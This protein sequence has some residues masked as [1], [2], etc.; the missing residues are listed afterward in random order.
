MKK[1][2][3]SHISCCCCTIYLI[4]IFQFQFHFMLSYW[5]MDA[6]DEIEDFVKHISVSFPTYFSPYLGACQREKSIWNRVQS[7]AITWANA[8]GCVKRGGFSRFVQL[9]IWLAEL[10]GFRIFTGICF[11]PGLEG[12]KTYM[13]SFTGNCSFSYI[14]CRHLL[15]ASLFAW[16]DPLRQNPI[17][18][19]HTNATAEIHMKYNYNYKHTNQQKPGEIHWGGN[20]ISNNT[21]MHLIH[22]SWFNPNRTA[23]GHICLPCHVSAYICANTRTSAL[24]KL[25]FSQL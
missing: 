23:D 12:T 2:N 7:F 4:D 8:Q 19:I 5:L 24:K 10:S 3:G 13:I 21:L 20:P 17:P 15:P 16:K 25:D 18:P 6:E 14:L 22:Q 9:D 1:K 11:G